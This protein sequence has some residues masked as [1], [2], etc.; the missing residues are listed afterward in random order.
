MT[1]GDSA[2]V[3]WLDRGHRTTLLI[4]CSDQMKVIVKLQEAMTGVTLHI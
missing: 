3:V 1:E 4:T 2:D